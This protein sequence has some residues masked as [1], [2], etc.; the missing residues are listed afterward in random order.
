MAFPTGIAFGIH[1][2][3][4]ADQWIRTIGIRYLRG[5]ADCFGSQCGIQRHIGH[6]QHSGGTD[7]RSH[8]HRNLRIVYHF[9]RNVGKSSHRMVLY[10]WDTVLYTVARH[11]LYLL[12]KS[13]MAEQKDIKYKR[14][15]YIC[16]W[17]HHRLHRLA[18]ILSISNTK[19]VLIRVIRGGFYTS[20]VIHNSK[21]CSTI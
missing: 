6:R 9:H 17:F 20:L 14:F 13:K 5:H 21:I 2:R 15:L 19:S 3:G 10:N 12:Q 1:Q 8:H 7:A 16:G 4:S 18:Q 11:K